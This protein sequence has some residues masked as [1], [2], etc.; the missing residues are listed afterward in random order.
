VTG[1]P[2]GGGEITF[3]PSPPATVTIDR[4]PALAV[5]KTA[6]VQAAEVGQQITYTFTVTNTGNVTITDP[7]VADTDFSGT[8]QL[9]PLDCP[10]GVVL[11]PGDNTTCTATYTLTQADI[12]A[13]QLTNAATATG[14]A[15]EGVTP[16][17]ADAPP[18]TVATNPHPALSLVK[19]ASA[20]QVTQVGQ[21]LTYTFAVTNT[22]NVDISDPKVN[23]G[24]FTGHGTLSPVTCPA[25]KTLAP[26][27]LITCTATYT[28]VAADLAD[29]ATLSNTATVTGTT[30]G[31]DPLTSDPSTAKVKEVAPAAPAGLALTGSDTWTAGLV[32]LGLLILGLL[33]GA[34]VWIQR[35]HRTDG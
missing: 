16:P 22:G 11:L 8:G 27:Q 5:V 4:L 21:V 18:V 23:E 29:A 33:A 31:G 9:S 17:T 25:G 35:R 30:P 7:K 15:P 3:P 6:N 10:V 26:G 20:Q 1:T 14:T 28:V 32:G 2:P 19:T 13:G 12:N 24:A 34:A